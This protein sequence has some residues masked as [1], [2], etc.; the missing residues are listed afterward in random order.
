MLLFISNF[1]LL[2]QSVSS[3]DDTEKINELL[4]H[5]KKAQPKDPGLWWMEDDEKKKGQLENVYLQ[6][7]T[8]LCLCPRREAKRL[9]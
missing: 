5:P 8:C 2:I 4:R 7:S 9:C 3:E 1:V 6:C